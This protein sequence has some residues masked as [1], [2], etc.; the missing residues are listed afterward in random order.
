MALYD[1]GLILISDLNSVDNEEVTLGQ[2]LSLNFYFLYLVR[3][4][5][6][7]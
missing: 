5:M 2:F 6:V 3:I 7:L 4:I 1:D